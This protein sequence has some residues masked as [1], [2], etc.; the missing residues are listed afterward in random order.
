MDL[1]HED[2]N[3]IIRRISDFGIKRRPSDD[4]RALR[5]LQMSVL[6]ENPM[7]VRIDTD[8]LNGEKDRLHYVR[9]DGYQKLG[10][11]Y[12]ESAIHL[13]ASKNKRVN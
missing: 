13:I 1:G 6:D 11:R 8:D 7:W 2:I 9:P 5:N 10:E 3:L 4:W 12:V